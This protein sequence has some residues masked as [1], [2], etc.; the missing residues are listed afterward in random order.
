[1]RKTEKIKQHERLQKIDYNI[2][3][4]IDVGRLLEL[5]TTNKIY[6]NG[7][8]LHEKESENLID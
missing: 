7:L 2:E 1:M 3:K 4:Y 8:N 5:P 6:V